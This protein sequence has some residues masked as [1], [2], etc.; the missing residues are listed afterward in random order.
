MAGIKFNIK[1]EHSRTYKNASKELFKA[2][3]EAMTDIKDDIVDTSSSL[4]PYKTGKLEKSHTVKKT[5]I[6]LKKISFEI[7]YNAFN[8]G[9][10]YAQWTHDEFYHL[11]EGSK[12][13]RPKKGKF[14]NKTFSVGKRYLYNAT[15]G[16]QEKG[17]KYIEDKMKKRVSEYFNQ[18][19]D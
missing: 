10:N 17:S 18:H 2:V 6:P 15:E 13:K 3:E 7:A 16:V 12:G 8:K 5:I 9:F 14:S 11:G 19:K 4:A 1:L